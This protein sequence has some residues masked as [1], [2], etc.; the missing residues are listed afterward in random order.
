MLSGGW[1]VREDAVPDSRRKD[2]AALKF[3]ETR[4]LLKR[5]PKESVPIALDEAGEKMDSPAFAR[6]LAGYKDRGRRVAFLVGGAFGLDR[7]ELGD[8]RTLSLSEMTYPHE[9]ATLMLMEQIYRANAS[10][11]GKSYA[12]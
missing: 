11:A 9:L 7:K 10:Y 2:T 6:L 3:E 8:T 1:R 4:A 12:K 5:I